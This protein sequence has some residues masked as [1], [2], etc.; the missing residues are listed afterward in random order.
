MDIKELHNKAMELA[1]LADFKMKQKETEQALSLYE[2]SYSLEKEAAMNAYKENT[3]EP[4]VSVL[5]SSAASLAM[6][7]KKWREAEKLITLALSG[8]PPSEIAEELRDLLKNVYDR[9]LEVKD[10]EEKPLGKT[11]NIVIY[12]KK[13]NK[14]VIAVDA[15]FRKEKGKGI[16]DVNYMEAPNDK[17][18]INFSKFDGIANLTAITKSEVN[19]ISGNFV[20]MKF[21]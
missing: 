16:K 6:D 11:N 18:K 1:A 10:A 7:C 4:T 20:S 13:E 5:L 14:F 9:P 17:E 3:G 12:V 19:V 2:Q 15:L 8:E 21:P